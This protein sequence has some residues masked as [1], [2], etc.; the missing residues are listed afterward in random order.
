MLACLGW[1][2]AR[3]H[4]QSPRNS[5]TLNIQFWLLLIALLIRGLLIAGTPGD[6]S[7]SGTAGWFL[8]E[9]R[10]LALSRVGAC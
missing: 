9:S 1:L 8:I 6:V 7:K 4:S 3:R 10:P 5:E 2:L